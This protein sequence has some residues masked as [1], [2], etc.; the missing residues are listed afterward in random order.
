MKVLVTGGTGFVGRSVVRHLIEAGHTVRTLLRPGPQSPR[1]PPGVPIQV[2]LAGLSDRRG[3]QAAL[4]GMQA[5]VHLASEERSGNPARLQATDVEGSRVLAEAAAQAGVRRILA[6]SHLGADR[7]AAYPVMR[8]KAQVEGFLRDCG[9]PY[10]VLRSGLAYG[11]SD[12][13]TTPLA[14][15][16]AVSPGFFPL[17]GDGQTRVQ[18]IWVED[19]AIAIT[20]ALEEPALSG[21][22]V[23]IG[24]PEHLTLEEAVTLVMTACGARRALWHLPPPYARAG[25]WVAGRLLRRPAFNGFWV[26]YLAVDRT[27]SLDSLPRL[28]GLQPARMENR[29]DH[30]R[31]GHWGRAYLRRQF[32]REA[33]A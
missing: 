16:L 25:L 8:A 3:V 9:V 5:V 12:H 21:R 19:L 17:I 26:D 28:F 18:P 23:E 27:T 24:G 1:L 7:A 10:T 4:V 11:E 20:W 30:L 13:F 29:L 32:A 14:M 15:S 2:A 6:L 22:V 31:G 33:G